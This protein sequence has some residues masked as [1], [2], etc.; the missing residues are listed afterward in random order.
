MKFSVKAL[1]VFSALLF[2]MAGAAYADDASTDSCT[3]C[4]SDYS[5]RAAGC[6]D[7]TLT[8]EAQSLCYTTAQSNLNSCTSN[9]SY[10]S[11]DN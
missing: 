8:A 3:S 7:S 4:Q 9:C 2:S 1:F 6:A 11:G 10:S 5:S